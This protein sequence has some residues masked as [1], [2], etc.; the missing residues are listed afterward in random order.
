MLAAGLVLAPRLPSAMASHWNIA[1]EVDGTMSKMAAVVIFPAMIAGSYLLFLVLIEILPLKD[2]VAA[3]RP[4]MNLFFVGLGIFLA[5]LNGIV[6]AWNLGLRFAIE[7]AVLPGIAVL[8]Y[9]IGHILGQARR[10][11]MF[12]IRT[13]WTLSSDR[14]WESTHRVGGL[15]FK[16]CA[17]LALLGAFLGETAAPMFIIPVALGSLAVVVYSYL[18]WRQE[19]A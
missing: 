3:F 11:W 18:V 14:V 10:N 17:G 4:Q 6:L 15:V 19:Q 8:L 5:Y 1:G 12:G 7:Q 13:P 16:V 2:N 9:L